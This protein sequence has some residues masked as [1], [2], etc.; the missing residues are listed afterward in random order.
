MFAGELM[1]GS[2]SIEIT[3]KTMLSTPRIGLHLSSADSWLLYSSVPGGCKIEM[4][5]L[6]S[7]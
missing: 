5:T 3:D 7:G 6:P 4:H 2:F 1:F